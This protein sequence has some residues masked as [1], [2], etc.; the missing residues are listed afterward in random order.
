MFYAT[1]PRIQKEDS[2]LKE[3]KRLHHKAFS[4]G[5]NNY[6]WT[7][8]KEIRPTSVR[9]KL[10]IPLTCCN[11]LFL[12]H[13]HF[14]SSFT[15]IILFPWSWSLSTITIYHF[16]SYIWSCY[17]QNRV[18]VTHDTIYSSRNGTDTFISAKTSFIHSSKCSISSG[19]NFPM[20]PILKQSALLTFPG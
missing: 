14:C 8:L 7:T 11:R 9:L 16:P 3:R 1:C 2:Y 17:W 10:L 13:P 12:L 15:L 5:Y 6:Y 4:A 19:Y 20:L 18:S